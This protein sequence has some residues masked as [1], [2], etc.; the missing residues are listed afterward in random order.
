MESIERE[1]DAEREMADTIFAIN[2]PNLVDF[3]CY[4]DTVCMGET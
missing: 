1:A 4:H 2:L 3:C